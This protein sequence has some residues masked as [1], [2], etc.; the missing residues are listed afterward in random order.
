VGDQSGAIHIWDLKTDHN[1][2]LIPEPEVSVNS[3]HID[4]DASYM[5][6]VN[7]SV[8]SG[9]LERGL[10]G[11]AGL[12]APAL[13]AALRCCGGVWKVR[14]A[15][16]W[17]PAH[18]PG[19]RPRCLGAGELLRVEPDGRHR[20]GGDAADPQ[21]QDPSAQP[22][23]P[24]VQVQPRL[25]VSACRRGADGAVGQAAASCASGCWPGLAPRCWAQGEWDGKHGRCWHRAAG[26]GI[27]ASCSALS[28][29]FAAT[30]CSCSWDGVAALQQ[31]S[32]ELG[33][34]LQRVCLA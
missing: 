34:L 30:S 12:R 27:P 6:A 18:P 15:L 20:R 4:P 13:P 25:H 22:L 9:G 31:Q 5:A 32:G 19:H 21:D 23:R 2:Q 33:V 7:S 26:S 17:L 24:A 3:V 14:A 28:A 8:S 16:G 1:E 11:A 29:S 10:C